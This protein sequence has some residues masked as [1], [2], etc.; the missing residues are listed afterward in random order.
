MKIFET[1]ELSPLG[2]KKSDAICKGFNRLSRMLALLVPPDEYAI[3]LGKLQEA[4]LISLQGM[5]ERAENR[6]R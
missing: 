1:H 3:V 4:F 6:K 5:S 2:E